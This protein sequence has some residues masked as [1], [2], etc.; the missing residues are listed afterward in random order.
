MD[1]V[2]LTTSSL[3]PHIFTCFTCEVRAPRSGLEVKKIRDDMVKSARSHLI[4]QYLLKDKA[5]PVRGITAHKIK[6]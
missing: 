4:T 3:T 1:L 2:D 5:G 6:L